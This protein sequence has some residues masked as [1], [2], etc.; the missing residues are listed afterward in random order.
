MAILFEPGR[1][2]CDGR[3]VLPRTPLGLATGNSIFRVAD[4][5][6][7][8]REPLRGGLCRRLAEFW[9]VKDFVA[10]NLFLAVWAL[11]GGRQVGF[12]SAMRWSLVVSSAWCRA[13]GWRSTRGGSIVRHGAALRPGGRG[14]ADLHS[15]G[16]H[17]VLCGTV[18]TSAVDGCPRRVEWRKNSGWSHGLRLERGHAGP[19]GGRM[20]VRAARS[21]DVANPRVGPAEKRGSERNYSA[22]L[23]IRGS[24]RR[25]RPAPRPINPNR[26]DRSS[27]TRSQD[28]LTRPNP[29]GA[30][31]TRA[32]AAS[33]FLSNWGANKFSATKAFATSNSKWR[34]PGPPLRAPQASREQT[35]RSTIEFL[36][37][38]HECPPTHSSSERTREKDLFMDFFS[39][40]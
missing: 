29:V 33:D 11:G 26:I 37:T 17:G 28:Q 31:Q 12:S 39:E 24:D 10:G 13:P 14:G 21:H 38:N 27:R 4:K 36:V 23:R 22:I 6:S 40:K 2:F 15:G 20:R 30:P 18:T 3:H 19:S 8:V 32:T 34:T 35:D 25:T 16:R 9:V 5:I 1:L 7:V